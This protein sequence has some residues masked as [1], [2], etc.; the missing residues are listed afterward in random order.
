MAALLSSP[1]A[2]TALGALDRAYYFLRLQPGR[3]LFFADGWGDVRR[4]QEWATTRLIA[5]LAGKPG[6][7]ASDCPA[8]TGRPA[9][10]R[11]AV[12]L[13]RF[14]KLDT[15]PSYSVLWAKTAGV[16]L[17][18]GEFLSPAADILPEESKTV[19]FIF[20]TP[21][22]TDKAAPDYAS[23]LAAH[24]SDPASNTSSSP[25]SPDALVIHLPATGEQTH[26]LRLDIPFHLARTRGWCSIVPIAA[27]YGSRRPVGQVQHHI[28]TVAGF[29]AQSLS[30][31][32]EAAHL[33]SLA[34]SL[35]PKAVVGITGFSWGA[36]MAGCAGLISSAMLPSRGTVG[37]LAVVPYV[38][39]C[40]PTP[41]VDGILQ[42][43]IDW[44]ALLRDSRANGIPAALDVQDTVLPAILPED[45]TPELIR[46]RLFAV[47]NSQHSARFVEA[48][49]Q[50]RLL[51]AGAHDVGGHPAADDAAPH[52][53]SLVCVSAR[54]DHFVLPQYSKELFDLLASV[55]VDGAA[56]DVQ[57]TGGHVTAFLFKPWTWYSAIERAVDRLLPRA[58]A[59]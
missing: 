46:E 24:F 36:A 44:E 29:L 48:L 22:P 21:S 8:A 41:F 18:E 10:A 53:D 16:D 11:P 34:E 39:S 9:G 1:L 13:T 38:G 15:I 28:R 7:E 50:R 19:H 52:I 49:K 26:A 56:E 32:T 58:K 40:S 17:W 37:R 43:D 35:F 54:D 14:A 55:T 5:R 23:R 59:N 2:S 31:M 57:A 33:A 27:F 42:N 51:G 20:V 6:S 45:A 30:I 47:M 25:P 3:P 12:T 4:V